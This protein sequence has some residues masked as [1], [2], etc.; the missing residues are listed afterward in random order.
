MIIEALHATIFLYQKSNAMKV[1]L[2][3][4]TTDFLWMTIA[5]SAIVFVSMTV[6]VRLL[7]HAWQ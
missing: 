1:K 5:A 3:K 7:K 6:V 4:S 2:S